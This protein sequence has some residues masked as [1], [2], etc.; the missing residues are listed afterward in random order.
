MEPA[1]ETELRHRGVDPRETRLRVFPRGEEFTIL[2]PRNLSTDR[3]TLHL[4]EIRRARTDEVIKFSPHELTHQRNRRFR[5][6]PIER[7]EHGDE[8]VIKHSRRHAPE[9]HVRAEGRR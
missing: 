4:V 3:V 8:L 2:V 1:L 9:F 5:V 6:F 7:L